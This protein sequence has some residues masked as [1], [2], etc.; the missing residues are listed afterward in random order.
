M[1]LGGMCRPAGMY[2]CWMRWQITVPLLRPALQVPDCA[3]RKG[4]P[5]TSSGFKACSFDSW[6]ANHEGETK[7]SSK[8]T[9]SL[10]SSTNSSSRGGHRWPGYS[11]ASSDKEA[12][13]RRGAVTL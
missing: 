13:R 10:S 6:G 2:G 1:E 8:S 7:S 3:Q 12:V 5:T 11:G 9:E 4:T